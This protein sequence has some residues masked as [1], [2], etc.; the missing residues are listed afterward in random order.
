MPII[1]RCHQKATMENGKW[2]TH[3]RKG[4]KNW[5]ELGFFSLSVV[6]GIKFVIQE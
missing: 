2:Y 1:R 6:I 5:N 4:H 3:H